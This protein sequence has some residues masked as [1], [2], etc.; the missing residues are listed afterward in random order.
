MLDSEGRVKL[1]QYHPSHRIT[2]DPPSWGLIVV[3]CELCKAEVMFGDDDDKFEALINPC[4]VSDKQREEFDRKMHQRQLVT[5]DRC[6]IDIG[7]TEVSAGMLPAFLEQI[8]KCSATLCDLELVVC[9]TSSRKYA[10]KKLY[11]VVVTI[12]AIRYSNGINVR[13]WFEDGTWS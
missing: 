13:R 5:A 7:F 4:P 9:I 1:E 6:P 3:R 8:E 11:S 10:G 12:P 2:V